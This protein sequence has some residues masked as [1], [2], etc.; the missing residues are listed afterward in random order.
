M[1]KII[2]FIT[3]CVVGHSLI[4]KGFTYPPNRIQIGET[5]PDFT[6]RNLVNYQTASTRI[7]EFHGKTIILDFFNTH[8]IPCIHSLKKLD[9]IQ[10]EH[11]SNLKILMVSYE[12]K[13]EIID[14]L[15]KNRLQNISL[16]FITGDSLI[17]RYV[18][19]PYYPYFVIID[20]SGK[21]KALTDYA[22]MT[23]ENIS[24][25]LAGKPVQFRYVVNEHKKLANY[26]KPLLID[27]NNVDANKIIFHTVFT[28]WM[29]GIRGGG[30]RANRYKE[31]PEIC[32]KI[33]GTNV[34]LITLYQFAY[35]SFDELGFG[36][37]TFGRRNKLFDDV[38][39]LPSTKI[40]LAVTDIAK[41]TPD[42][43]HI[44]EWSRQNCFSYD[45]TVPP[46]L[47]DSVLTMMQQDLNRFLPYTATMKEI[48]TKCLVLRR[49]N[50]TEKLETA[51]G[52]RKFEVTPNYIIA[53]NAPFSYL[54]WELQQRFLTMKY[55]TFKEAQ[56]PLVDETGIQ[57]NID[58]EIHTTI[59]DPVSLGKELRRY[60]LDLIEEERTVKMLVIT[61]K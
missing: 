34:G 4:G 13:K 8:C 18:N 43:L 31:N 9:S 52:E 53:A 28:K 26:N 27:S 5:F 1:K 29:E 59:M 56:Y 36:E 24:K 49:I 45:I 37:I 41:F 6:I 12:S 33:T 23:K 7:S 19:N 57:G 51:G 10:R 35:G 60:G 44:E 3:L 16:T 47:K 39:P 2:L 42:M 17:H 21:I 50:K 38:N 25:Y 22:S 48:K 61:D 15:N 11:N 40:K 30:V 58:M 32:A 46:F 14:C 54:F 55:P 20:D